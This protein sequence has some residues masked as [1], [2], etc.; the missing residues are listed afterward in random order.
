[1][2]RVSI[3]VVAVSLAVAAIA[4]ACG[5]KRPVHA[6]PGVPGAS[7][8]ERPTNLAARDL[9]YGPWGRDYAPDP[10]AVYTFLERKHTGVNL[11]MTVR[12]A[13]GR[14]WSVKQ[15][16]PGGLDDESSVEVTVS[17]ILSA[18]GYHQPPVY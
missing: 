2:R 16:Y 11:G 10:G 12:D 9:F 6:T 7:L 1:M 5:A 15:P 8:W 13:H 18:V 4:A 17:R 14:D 3:A